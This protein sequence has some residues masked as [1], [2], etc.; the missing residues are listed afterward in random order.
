[1]DELFLLGFWSNSL[2]ERLLMRS[3]NKYII[4]VQLARVSLVVGFAP[5]GFL[6]LGGDFLGTMCRVVPK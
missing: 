3:V 5:A 2:S 6:V 4:F 1:M